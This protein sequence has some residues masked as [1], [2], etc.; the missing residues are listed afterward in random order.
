MSSGATSRTTQIVIA[1]VG[2]AE[3]RYTRSAAST[4]KSGAAV[5]E[6]SSQPGGCERRL[7]AAR[8]L[9]AAEQE[10]LTATRQAALR[11]LCEVGLA[12]EDEEEEDGESEDEDN[13]NDAEE[14]KS[15]DEEDA[16]EVGQAPRSKRVR[17]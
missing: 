9:C 13:V 11:L 3:R 2:A 8:A 10:A 17:R 15:E 7:R 12:E 1:A 14:C 6:G 5:G 4:G 16:V